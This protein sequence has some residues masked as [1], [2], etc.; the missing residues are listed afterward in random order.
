MFQG[1]VRAPFP[2]YTT[3]R[4]LRQHANPLS[5]RFY[6]RP[7]RVWE[8][9]S[10]LDAPL[11]LDIGCGEGTMLVELARKYPH[12]NHLGVDI[13]IGAV[14]RA[15]KQLL[16]D[17]IVS[18]Q[19]NCHFIVAN[20]ELSHPLWLPY[21]GGVVDV[22]T[23]F[24][25]DPLLKY[26]QR[27]KRRLV[28]THFALALASYTNPGHTRLHIQSDSQSIFDDICRT[29][30]APSA[31]RFFIRDSPD[32]SR[33]PF[34]PLRSMRESR[35]LQ[36]HFEAMANA[37]SSG[38]VRLTDASLADNNEDRASPIDP[39]RIW[40]A[41]YTRTIAPIEAPPPP[42]PR[43]VA[44]ISS[45]TGVHNPIPVNPASGS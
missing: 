37:H 38:V 36:R 5:L 34:E 2:K 16:D 17:P 31:A 33:G 45:S 4:G 15:N 18:R 8:A 6:D 32:P 28:S 14:T 23:I 41:S 25:P 21:P 12:R 7:K 42:P 19:G 24:H 40:R 20:L 27:E 10:T 13:R 1:V 44:L 30:R 3:L 43:P 11:H 22:I 35:I 39:P 9:F 26:T 29:L